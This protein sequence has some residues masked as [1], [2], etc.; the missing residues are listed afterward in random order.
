MWYP[1]QVVTESDGVPQKETTWGGSLDDMDRL[2]Y[3][4]EIDRKLTD[5]IAKFL[6][7]DGYY[8]RRS[9]PCFIKM[10]GLDEEVALY[11]PRDDVEWVTAK[12][13][14]NGPAQ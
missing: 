5:I 13:G 7:V 9:P 4:T 10:A 3:N 6:N 8:V 12:T 1:A 14:N 2:S 11:V